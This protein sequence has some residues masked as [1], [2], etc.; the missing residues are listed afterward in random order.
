[1]ENEEVEA[2]KKASV[3]SEWSK[4]S[5]PK[6]LWRR[7]VV[8]Y[9]LMLLEWSAVQPYHL[10]H[11]WA[12]RLTMVS[13]LVSVS[14]WLLG[15]LM[16]RM[17]HGLRSHMLIRL[18][19]G[20]SIPR[21]VFAYCFVFFRCTKIVHRYLIGVG[22]YHIT[23]AGY[24]CHDSFPVSSDRMLNR[25]IFILYCVFVLCDSQLRRNLVPKAVD[26]SWIIVL[27]LLKMFEKLGS[28]LIYLIKA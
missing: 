22:V 15:P 8:Q 6:R 1:M 20:P 28:L 19:L 24:C 2:T 10:S 13:L 14:R 27:K 4:R 16:F 11:L 7:L 18:D 21:Y 17:G 3:K 26:I 23:A 12:N 5:G 9:L 25:Y